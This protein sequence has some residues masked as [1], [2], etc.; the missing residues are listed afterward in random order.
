MISIICACVCVCPCVCVRMW[1]SACMC[2]CVRVCTFVSCTFC[3]YYWT[4]HSK[5]LPLACCFHSFVAQIYNIWISV[6]LV[7]LSETRASQ[8]NKHNIHN[9]KKENKQINKQMYVCIVYPGHLLRSV[10]CRRVCL[11]AVL[12]CT[13]TNDSRWWHDKKSALYYIWTNDR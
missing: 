8:M 6:S 2:A 13:R 12:N 9:P 5:E 10:N 11:Q 4:R 7:E 1:V 3:L